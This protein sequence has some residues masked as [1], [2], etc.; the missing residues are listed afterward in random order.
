MPTPQAPSIAITPGV[1][2]QHPY[3][4]ALSARP[5]CVAAFS[6]RSDAQVRQYT[7]S[8][9]RPRAVHYLYP[10]DPDPRRQDAAK[11][12]IPADKNSL[13]NQVHL[14]IH[15]PR[16]SGSIMFTWECWMG[17]EFDFANTGIT[18]YKH[19]Q[20]G[21]PDSDIWCEVCSRFNRGSMP[22][23]LADIDGRIYISGGAT[24]GSNVT[25]TNPLS[26]RANT[27]L[28]PAE[29]F[30]RYWSLFEPEG[31]LDLYSLWVATAAAGVMPLY[32]QREL[33]MRVDPHGVR[34]IGIFR[35][36]F[37][38]STNE[39]A[40]GRTPLVAYVRNFVELQGITSSTIAPL[41]TTEGL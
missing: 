7:A 19:F 41:L 39:V 26:P 35:C 4:E 25:D 27:F 5:D 29:T 31:D 32:H 6:L 37:N 24:P 33:R 21:S 30:V 16:S 9:S 1:L 8:T 12:V 38:T 18:K 20:H 3:F 2:G 40:L 22:A 23:T 11:V 17:A 10:H 15:W 13:P 14:P 28:Y 36:E 34:K